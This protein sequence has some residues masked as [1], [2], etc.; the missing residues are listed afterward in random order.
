[1]LTL[2]A[3]GVSNAVR[4]FQARNTLTTASNS[5]VV[6][7]NG[8]QPCNVYWQVGSSTTLGTTT[9]FVGNIVAL[10]KRFPVSVDRRLEC[11]GKPL[12]HD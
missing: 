2:D 12:Q 1:V 7:I 5:S 9:S 10:A 4:V 3:E 6:L 11:A 8:G